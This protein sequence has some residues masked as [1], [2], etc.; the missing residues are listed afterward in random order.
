MS[1]GERRVEFA[2]RVEPAADETTGSMVIEVRDSGPGLPPLAVDR[3]FRRGFSTKEEGSAGRRGIGLALV[4]QSVERL[5]GTLTVDGPPG[6]VFT[7]R[8]PLQGRR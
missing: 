3:A 1:D 4:S 7:V 2:T 6:A 8:L 5:G